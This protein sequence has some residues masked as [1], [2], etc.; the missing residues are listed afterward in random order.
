MA[1]PPSYVRQYVLIFVVLGLG[2][3]L[4]LSLVG[5]KGM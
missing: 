3:A 4:R 5:R 2:R 1:V